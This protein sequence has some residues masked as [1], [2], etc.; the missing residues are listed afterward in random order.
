MSQ[1]R[2][3]SRNR[4]RETSLYAGLAKF[5]VS[6]RSDTDP[7]RSVERMRILGKV[8]EFALHVK[9]ADLDKAW[10]YLVSCRKDYDPQR[11]G[12]SEAMSWVD[13]WDA[14]EEIA[15]ERTG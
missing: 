11:D 13:D 1:A 6:A 8:R 5:E 4:R 9:E 10:A 3:I 15:K 14:L 12:L 7:E 2:R